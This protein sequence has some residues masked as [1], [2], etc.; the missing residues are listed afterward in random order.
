MFKVISKSIFYLPA[1]LVSGLLFVGLLAQ[2]QEPTLVT[3]EEA[4][5]CTMD[6]MQCP[7]GSYVGRTGPNCEFVCPTDSEANTST[8]TDREATKEQRAEAMEE[9]KANMADT[10][11][12][13]TTAVEERQANRAVQAE[14]RQEVRAE[15]QS[16]LT[17]V[18]QERII[19]LSA[20][21]SNR[22]DAA[23]ERLFTI[24]GRLEARITKLSDNG[25][26]TATAT[27]AL[28]EAAASLSEA[29]VLLA[30]I[31]TLVNGATTS[32]APYSEWQSVREQYKKIGELIRQ[33]HA[34]LRKTVALL[35]EAVRANSINN[36]GNSGVSPA[37]TPL[38][39]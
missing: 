39:E 9:R 29:K 24:I 1:M 2:A 16:A 20:N 28:R 19:N 14:A 38:S 33:S 6:A 30:N 34:S 36:A 26:D 31:D 13:Q 27:A 10:L 7:N 17:K 12:K 21:I 4:V 3:E 5:A 32:E 35:K 15:R 25:V 11:E 22:M 18:R 37:V 23:V 8:N